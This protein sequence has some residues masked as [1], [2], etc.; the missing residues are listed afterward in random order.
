MRPDEVTQIADAI[1]AAGITSIEVPLNS[2]DPLDSIARLVKHSGDRALIGAGTVLTPD[3]VAGVAGAG[4]QLIVSPDCNPAV[5]DAT[6]AAGLQSF[7]GVLTPTEA[8]TALRH[9]AD[10]LKFFPGNLVGEA[11]LKAMMAVLPQGTQT[12]AVGGAAPDNFAD[13]IAA[14]ATGFG[15]GSGLYQAGFDAEEV[16]KRAAAIVSAFDALVAV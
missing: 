11:G 16:G 14:G 4:G 3:D 8:F 13:W 15:I 9:G 12:F 10:G 5:I 6:K 7:P 2:P 1:M